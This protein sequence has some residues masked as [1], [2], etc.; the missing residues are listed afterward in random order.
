MRNIK[1]KGDILPQYF[2]F[3][4]TNRHIYENSKNLIPFG[5]AF[6]TIV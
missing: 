6:G 2:H 4:G 3:L 5:F 1:I